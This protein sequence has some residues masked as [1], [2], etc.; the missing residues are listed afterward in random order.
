MIIK[1]ELSKARVSG[2]VCNLSAVSIST[3]HDDKH[4][5]GILDFIKE[6][7]NSLRVPLSK[8]VLKKRLKRYISSETEFQY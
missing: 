4:L 8:R 7:N 6:E 1:R 5:N 3:A 2:L